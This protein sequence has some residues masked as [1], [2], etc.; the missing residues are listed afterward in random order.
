MKREDGLG[1][2]TGASV[3]RVKGPSCQGDFSA[4]RRVKGRRVMAAR[5]R[6]G[7]RMRVGGNGIAS[8][9]D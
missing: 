9:G 4:A 1:V 3:G 5:V 2:M 6:V 8:G 7:R